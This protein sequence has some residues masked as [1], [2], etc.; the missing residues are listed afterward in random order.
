[1]SGT[2]A[3][4]LSREPTHSVLRRDEILDARSP[5]VRAPHLAGRPVSRHTYIKYG[6]RC[7][8][9]T[10]KNRE[11]SQAWRRRKGVE[12]G[13]RS[14]DRRVAR[15]RNYERKLRENLARSRALAA[16][17]TLHPLDYQR[18]VAVARHVIDAERG[19]LPGDP[20]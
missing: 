15:V 14:L 19:P 10:R 1:M 11:G 5:Q 4:L 13:P 12:P 16:L 8:G 2:P 20:T 9:C 7:P 6:C 17:A 18:L 3:S